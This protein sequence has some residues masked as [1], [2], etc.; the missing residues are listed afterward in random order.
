MKMD[1][2]S[3]VNG[4]HNIDIDE[5]D[6]APP[7]D[8]HATGAT[9]LG[10]PKAMSLLKEY[11]TY[12]WKP[13]PNLSDDDNYMDLVMVLTR[14]SKLR[15]GSMACLLVAVAAAA[16]ADN[17]KG[18][19]DE[20]AA[21][22]ESEFIGRIISAST[23]RPFYNKKDSDI[24]AEISALG[25]AASTKGVSTRNASAYVSVLFM[26][27]HDVSMVQSTYLMDYRYGTLVYHL[28]PYSNGM[29][30]FLRF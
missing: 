27:L 19:E 29:H 22:E 9:G 30:A 28:L 5:G 15:Q 12:G 17:K 24:H 25:L 8:E 7:A 4:R 10:Q 11:N 1:E 21:T 3:N 18:D 20:D 2:D 26:L 16:D 13:D 14:N 6:I 23:N